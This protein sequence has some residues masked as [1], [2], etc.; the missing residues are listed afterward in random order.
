MRYVLK[1]VN[2]LRRGN[3]TFGMRDESDLTPQSFHLP[4]LKEKLKKNGY[5]IAPCRNVPP[6][7]VLGAEE[8]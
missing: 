6:S 3:D 1:R 7:R 2:L 5:K 4:F 8:E